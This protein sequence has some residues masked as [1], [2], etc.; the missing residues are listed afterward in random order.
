MAMST[1]TP[2]HRGQGDVPDVETLATDHPRIEPQTVG[3]L[4]VADVDG[5]HRRRAGLEQ[6]V[7]EAAGRSTGIEGPHDRSGRART[8]R[9]RR[10]ASPRPG[11]R[12]GRG[13]APARRVRPAGHQ[14]RR[15]CRPPIRRTRTRPSP[16]RALA[17][18]RLG[19][20]PARRGPGRAVA[21]GSGSVRRPVGGRRRS[22]AVAFAAAVP[23]LPGSWWPPP[24][25]PP[26]SGPATSW[27]RL[28]WPVVFLAAVGLGRRR[29]AGAG[30][31]AA[32]LVGGLRVDALSVAVAARPAS[33]VRPRS[34]ATCLARSS[35]L[36]MPA[37]S[38][39]RATS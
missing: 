11:S 12:S 19:P 39:W 26:P 13:P 8:G 33:A 25:C 38:S 35:R 30:L 24:W 27:R 7:G 37:L 34:A 1:G 15:A 28:W 20:S 22:V 23:F 17:W 18:A 2:A 5:D 36:V 4:T 29:L 31:P 6:A 21:A 10:P 14:S 3:Q 16:M 32:F 9:G